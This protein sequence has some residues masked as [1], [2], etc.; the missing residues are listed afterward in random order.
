MKKKL[1]AVVTFALCCCGCEPDSL[2]LDPQW[3]QYF[4]DWVAENAH[5]LEPFF[6][7]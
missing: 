6:R 2:A 4:G 5:W 3:P 1:L 7:G